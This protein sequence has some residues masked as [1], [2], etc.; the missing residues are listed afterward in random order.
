M[1]DDDVTCYLRTVEE[2]ADTYVVLAAFADSHDVRSSYYV[3]HLDAAGLAA[4]ERDLDA[5]THAGES[6]EPVVCA[7][8]A[9]QGGP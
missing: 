8:V 2:T 7:W 5:A 9:V 1:T 3:R 6:L 4:F